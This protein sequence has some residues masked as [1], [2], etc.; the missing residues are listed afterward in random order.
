MRTSAKVLHFPFAGL[1]RSIS[2]RDNTQPSEARTYGTPIA[3][4]VRGSC[5]FADRHRGGSR[6][7]LTIVEGAT[8]DSK[9]KWLW[10]N[11]EP[12]LWPGGNAILFLDPFAGYHAPD[13]SRFLDA[14]AGVVVSASKGNA[15]VSPSLTTFYRAR[16]IAADGASWFASATGDAGNWDYGGDSG[17]PSRAV[18]GNLA[19]AGRKGEP[20][21]AFMAVDDSRL[22]AATA[23]SLWVM[24]EPTAGMQKVSDSVGCVG[25]NAW[26]AANGVLYTLSPQGL[27]RVVPGEVPVRVDAEIPE[28]LKGCADTALLAYD[29]EEDAVHVFTDKG[30]FFYEIEGKAFWPVALRS[31]HRPIACARCVLDGIDRLLL[32]GSDGTWRRFSADAAPGESCVA[33]GPFRTSGRDDEDGMLDA[34]FVVLAAGSAPVTLEIYPARTAEAAYA[35]AASKDCAPSFATNIHPGITQT[36]RPRVRG[37]WCVVVLRGSGRWAFE[38][39]TATCKQLGRLR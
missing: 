30:D 19:L 17:D 10:P 16:A 33:I 18:S 32:L 23:R 22:Y 1:S 28:E 21:T 39:A 20:I 15:P 31:Y 13:G 25:A 26:C 9:G 8:A 12:I 6:P 2:V 3:S 37:A 38:T 4:N 29:P 14:H 36:V 24:V 5:T 7:G 27:F 11:G 34:L 35:N